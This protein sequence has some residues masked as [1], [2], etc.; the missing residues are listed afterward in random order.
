MLSLTTENAHRWLWLL[1]AAIALALGAHLNAWGVLESSEARYAEIGR[2]MLA[3][4]DWLHPRL[5][6]IQHFHKPPLTYWLTAAGLALTGGTATAAGVRLLPLLAVLTQVALVYGLG[7]LLFA[8]DRV[9]ALAA[10]VVYAT[11]PVVL[12]SALNVTTDA[13][14]ATWELAATFGLL[15]FYQSHKP[16]WLYLFWL[17]LGLAFLTKGPVGFILPLMAV[18]GFY[19]RRQP[20]RRPF[21]VH[22]ALGFLLFGGVGLS[23]YGYLVAENPA[24]VRYFLFEHTVERFAN[25]D[26]FARSKPWWFYLVLAPATSLPW[27]AALLARALRTPWTSLPPIWR[28]VLLFG[29]LVPLGFFS[30]SGSKLL[31]YILPIFPGVALLTV[32][33]L[34]RCTD[35]ELYHWYGG[36]LLFFGLILAVL[37]ALPA[38]VAAWELPLE[39]SPLVAVWAAVGAGALA[40]QHMLWQPVR[41]AP[42]LLV[43]PVIF[44]VFLLMSAKTVLSENELRFNGTRPLA[45]RLARPDLAGRPV[46]VYNELLPSL[47]FSLGRLPVSLYDGNRSLRRETQFEHDQAWQRRLINLQDSTAPPRPAAALSAAPVLV[48]KGELPS[49]RQG[50]RAGLPQEEQLGPWRIYYAPNAPAG[51]PVRRP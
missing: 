9:R 27:S 32:Y 31:L 24:F 5:L 25:P 29:I 30:L 17:M 1:L 15:R 2:E 49:A 21:T 7:A 35:A 20:P 12:I 37:S 51:G 48:V 18:A 33:Y 41:V 22:H 8:G 19:F 43:L 47:A 14:L 50:L 40:L 6:G 4:H 28:N 11:L 46:L 3:G 42:R 44:T 36:F 10:A 13:Y 39:A 34:G 38:V 23:W 26:T 45:A 16:G